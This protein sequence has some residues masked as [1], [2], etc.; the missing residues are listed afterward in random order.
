M[1]KL[2]SFILF[3]LYYTTCLLHPLYIKVLKYPYIFFSKC[4]YQSTKISVPIHFLLSKA[5]TIRISNGIK[6]NSTFIFSKEHFK[7][8]CNR[9]RQL[10]CKIK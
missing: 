7:S 6:I 8:N 3:I 10:N 2:C 4:L 1:N 5:S 9:C